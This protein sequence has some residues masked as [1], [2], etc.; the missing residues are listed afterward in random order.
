MRA[1][2]L[3]QLG[4]VDESRP[5][6]KSSK[7]EVPEPGQGQVRLRVRACGVCH[8]ELDEIEGRTAPPQLPVVPGHEVVGVVDAVGSGCDLHKPGDRLGV[9]WI[10]DSCGEC[11]YCRNG[12][13]NL[14]EGF[15][16]TGR[17]ANGGYAEYM[18]VPENS[19]YSI[20]ALYEDDEAA[21]LLC[22]GGVGY[23]SLRLAGITDGQSLGFYGFGASAHLVLQMARYL[24][25]A[26]YLAV[27]TRSESKQEF[28]IKLGADW[29]GP[30]GRR[31]P[32][33]LDALIDTTPVWSAIVEGLEWLAPAGRLVVNAIRKEDADKPSLVQMNYESHLWNEKQLTSVAN[34]TRK[35]IADA[36]EVCARAGIRPTVEQYPLE[37]A[38]RALIDLKKGSGMG[39][40]V[41]MV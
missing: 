28:A 3:T 40:K 31:P 35:D 27:V 25:P 29:A 20:S 24:Y 4:T 16:A 21:P 33:S 39:A 36:L 8:T 23:R 26:S 10:Y 5:P 22:A 41:L 14:C 19:A 2:V 32:R 7:I 30:P 37:D 6:L 13:E 11:E 34:V 17:D 12:L 38:N 18:L 1:M 15:V 9:G